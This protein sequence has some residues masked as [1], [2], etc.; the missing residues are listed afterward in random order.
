MLTSLQ[1]FCLSQA[2]NMWGL[3]FPSQEANAVD[4]VVRYA[5]T[6]L[7]FP[8]DDIIMYGWPIGGYTC[9]CAAAATPTLELW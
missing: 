5:V 2:V 8:L 1:V 3:P 4:V 6:K 9:S 7:G